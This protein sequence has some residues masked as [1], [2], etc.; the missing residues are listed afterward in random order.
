M[1][2][3]TRSLGASPVLVTSPFRVPWSATP[4]PIKLPPMTELTC[5]ASPIVMPFLPSCAANRDA[6]GALCDWA[7]HYSSC[8]V[9]GFT[10]YQPQT[11]AHLWPLPV[12]SMPAANQGGLSPCDTNASVVHVSAGVFGSNLGTGAATMPSCDTIQDTN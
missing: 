6:N 3:V 4:V 12:G 10:L 9:R 7:R 1:A 8:Q 11:L 5:F 2:W